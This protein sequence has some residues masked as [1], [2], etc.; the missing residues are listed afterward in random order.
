METTPMP[1]LYREAPVNAIWE[2]SGNVQCL[3][4]LRA[5]RKSP[6]TL[7]ALL[8]EIGRGAG[9]HPALD[10]RIAELRRQQQEGD[11]SPMAA[12]RFVGSLAQAWQA[13]LLQRAGHAPVADAYCS[14]RLEDRGGTGGALYGGLP[15]GV[16]CRAI[17]ERA[18]PE[19]VG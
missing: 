19:T 13:S 6:D 12:R 14:A 11:F 16:D 2:G 15:G 1:R 5:I 18:A 9:T 17:I 7:E 10:A 4:V 8:A 3:D